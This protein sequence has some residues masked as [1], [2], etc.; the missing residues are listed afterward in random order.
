MVETVA[1]DADT[2]VRAAAADLLAAVR[3]AGY[4]EPSD[5]V[6]IPSVDCCLMLSLRFVGQ[7]S[8]L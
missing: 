7:S 3:E 8:L 6:S 2:K 5:T 1:Q 4:P